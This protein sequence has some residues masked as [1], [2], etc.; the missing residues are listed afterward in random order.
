MKIK[1]AIITSAGFGTRFLPITKT[2]Q[3]E[4]L[5]ILNRPVIDYIVEDCIK[6]GIKEIIFVVNEH[7]KQVL[8]FYQENQ[9]LCQHLKKTSKLVKHQRLQKLH[10]KA[11]FRF[12]R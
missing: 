8:H 5:P 6:A 4:M 2:I 7:N 3:K 10:Q 11:K 9:R 1:K 12:I